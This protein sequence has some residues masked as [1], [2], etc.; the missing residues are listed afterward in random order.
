M[1][2]AMH[3]YKVTDNHQQAGFNNR[4]RQLL[5]L[6]LRLFIIMYC[7]SMYKLFSNREISALL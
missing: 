7:F 3:V 2:F 4:I 5:L 6:L 1:K